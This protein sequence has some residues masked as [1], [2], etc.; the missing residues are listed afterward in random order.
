MSES[1]VERTEQ[2][3]HFIY[4]GVP[5]TYLR[6]GGVVFVIKRCCRL[7]VYVG[8]LLYCKNAIRCIYGGLKWGG[9]VHAYLVA[10]I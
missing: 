10:S 1:F 6:A 9:Y 8:N 7:Y 3:L 5:Y 2:L 4:F